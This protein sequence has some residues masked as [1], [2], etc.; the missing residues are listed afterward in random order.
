MEKITPFLMFEGKAEDAMNFYISV[1]EDSE[2]TSISRYGANEAG[3]E[4]S[5]V[6]ATFTLKGREY[7]CID[8]NVKH[9]FTFTP[10]FSLFITA[11]TEEEIERLYKLLSE[12]GAVLMPLADYSF[13]RKFCWVVDKFGVAWQINLP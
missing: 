10:S 7:M 4:G 6:Q 5:V 12:D 9:N 8:S 13:S 1:I 2:I 11:D 3:E